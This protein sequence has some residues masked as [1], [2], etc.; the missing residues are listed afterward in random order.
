MEG[1]VRLMDSVLVVKQ[2]TSP[3]KVEDL[4]QSNFGNAAG[5]ID[6]L[7]E[8]AAGPLSHKAFTSV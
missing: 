6:E 1:N 3:A 8:S 5:F 7:F 4:S 2:N